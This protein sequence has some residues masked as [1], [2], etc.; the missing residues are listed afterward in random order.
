MQLP[1][2]AYAVLPGNA[3]TFWKKSRLNAHIVFAAAKVAPAQQA[4]STGWVSLQ[5][6]HQRSLMQ[7]YDE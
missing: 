6:D 7:D 5:N 2:K 1:L 3:W 4:S